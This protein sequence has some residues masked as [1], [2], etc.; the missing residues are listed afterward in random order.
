MTSIKSACAAL[1]SIAAAVFMLSAC[2]EQEAAQTQQKPAPQV[3]IVVLKSEPVALTSDLPGRT[4]AY[5]VAQVRPQVDGIVQKRLFTEGTEVKA[6]QQLYQIDP[7]MYNA[8]L[9][10]AS[11]TLAS[12]K[13]LTERYSALVKQQAVSRQSYDDARASMLQAEASVEQAR[14]NLRYTKVMAPITG[15]IDRSLVTEG[16][17]VSSRQD[18]ALAIIY[19]LD[20]IYVDVTQPSRELLRL[21][22][23][24]NEGRLQ[25][26]SDHAARITLTLEDGTQYQQEGT[27]EFAEV[28]V[29]QGTGSVT[30]RA[31]FPNPERTLLPG[32]FVYAK[33]VE[34]VQEQAILAPQQGITHDTKGNAVAMVVNAENKVESRPVVTGRTV[35]NRWLILDGLKEGDRLITEGLQ[36]IKPGAEVKAVP[37][38]NVA[39]SATEPPRKQE[40]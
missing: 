28:S 29:D 24:F 9:K 15:R 12:T 21:R 22:R 34:G 31:I 6:G 11:A 36:Y 39:G 8:V 19:Q 5:R 1:V 3:G 4:Q 18:Q 13:A 40:G 14:I 26:A 35:G 10:S 2:R 38:T 20:P 30:V 7:S 25:K 16:A 32:M 33:L 17:L 23:D 27:L 37:A